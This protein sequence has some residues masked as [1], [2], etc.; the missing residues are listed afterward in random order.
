MMERRISLKSLNPHITCQI[1]KGYLIDA[2]TVA[3]CLHTCEYH[4]NETIFRQ[5]IF[6][7][8]LIRADNLFPLSNL[9]I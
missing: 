8:Q 7:L 4:Q 3:E 1:C 5:V 9:F 2:T 6:Y